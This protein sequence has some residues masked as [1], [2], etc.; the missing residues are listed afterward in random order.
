MGGVVNLQN[1]PTRQQA[2]DVTQ[3]HL[4]ALLQ[5]REIRE[6]IDIF[7]GRSNQSGDKSMQPATRQIALQNIEQKLGELKSTLEKCDDNLQLK[8]AGGVAVES[9]LSR[10]KDAWQT[11]GDKKK[12][13]AVMHMVDSEL[14]ELR[15]TVMAHTDPALNRQAGASEHRSLFGKI[16]GT[17]SHLGGIRPA[18]F[19]S[20]VSGSDRVKYRRAAEAITLVEYEKQLRT[21]SEGLEA[22]VAQV[23]KAAGRKEFAAL[24]NQLAQLAPN[25][26]AAG[27]L[28]KTMDGLMTM[29]QQDPHQYVRSLEPQGNGPVH[30][31]DLKLWSEQLQTAHRSY[32]AIAKGLPRAEAAATEYVR[33]VADNLRL[34]QQLGAEREA[35]RER[36][37]SRNSVPAP[38][39]PLPVAPVLER[40]KL[41][42]AR[43][44]DEQS[45]SLKGDPRS[46]QTRKLRLPDREQHDVFVEPSDPHHRGLREAIKLGYCVTYSRNTQNE[47]VFTFTHRNG[48]QSISIRGETQTGSFEKSSA[49]FHRLVQFNLKKLTEPKETIS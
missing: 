36:S 7:L 23:T 30:L 19:P 33:I 28:V 44:Y 12:S 14:I 48:S 35:L 32:S 21:Q 41:D 34:Q 25:D 38:Q 45:N 5:T 49:S 1:N 22:L 42:I 37:E 18:S 40:P 29:K 6:Q 27:E 17:M 13:N 24:R 31:A 16:M 20:D 10:T 4:A 46:P 15:K 9:L 39:A 11:I 3:P 43:L 2:R 26:R 47:P 8:I